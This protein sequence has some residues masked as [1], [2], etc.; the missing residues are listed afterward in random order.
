MITYIFSTH[1]VLSPMKDGAGALFRAYDLRRGGAHGLVREQ[2][3][4]GAF[5]LLN[6]IG[7][8]VICPPS[9]KVRNGLRLCSSDK[10]SSLGFPIDFHGMGPILADQLGN[11][12]ET[13]EQGALPT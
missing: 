3:A 10:C 8:S 6:H 9:K 7:N 12:Y 5:C 11:P 4:G 13:G 1:H 2:N